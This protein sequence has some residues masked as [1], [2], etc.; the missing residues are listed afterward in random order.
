[1]ANA[2][3]SIIPFYDRASKTRA[4]GK[5]ETS[6]LIDQIVYRLYGPTEEEISVVEA[7]TKGD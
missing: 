5:G 2:R 7:S 3:T 4:R 6:Y 1:L